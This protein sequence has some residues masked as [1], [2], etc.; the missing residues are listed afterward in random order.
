[1]RRFALLIAL[2]LGLMA[3]CGKG[4]ASPTTIPSPAPTT[5]PTVPPAASPTA[6]AVACRALSLLGPVLEGLPPVTGEDWSRGPADAPITLIEYSDFECPGCAG[7][8]PLITL[9][10]EAYGDNLRFVYRHFPLDFHENAPIAAEAAEAA[11]AQGKFWEMHNM[12]FQRQAEWSGSA[13]DQ[14]MDLLAGYAQ[15]LELDVEQFSRDLADHTYREKVQNSY[16]AAT[17]MQLP[18]TPTFIVNGRLYPWDLSYQGLDAFIQLTLLEPRMYD[19]PPPQVIDPAKKYTA[20]IRTAKGDIVIELFADRVPVTVNSF[21]FLAREGWY[22]GV[23]F[24]RVIPDFVAQ[25]GD[26]TNLGVGSPGYGCDDEIVPTL[27]YDEVGMV[28]MA[29]QG[30]GTGTVGSQF[31]ITYAPL[32]QLNGSYTIIGRVIEGMDVA[33]SLTPRDP[34]QGPNLPPGDVIETIAIEER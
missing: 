34:N 17:T 7:M 19:G 20:T 5:P 30:A 2:V 6:S 16:N 9:L 26:P 31:F 32:S 21:V 33:R 3:G 11:G 18:G 22:D 25:T 1:M 8:D 29:S 28:G 12:L 13:A 10:E 15:E 4:T 27:T 23:T 24:F 14:I